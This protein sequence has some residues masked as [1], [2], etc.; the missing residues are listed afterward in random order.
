MARIA[1]CNSEPL[2]NGRHLVVSMCVAEI[3]DPPY[4]GTFFV[5]VDNFPA[6]DI[7]WEYDPVMIDF[8][9]PNPPPPDETT[10]EEIV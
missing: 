7:G 4:A 1:V 9:N 6:C 10:T 5:D 3:T 2:P 8:T